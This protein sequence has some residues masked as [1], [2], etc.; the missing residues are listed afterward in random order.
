MTEGGD[1]LVEFDVHDAVII[2]RVH[3]PGLG[4]RG[5]DETQRLGN[6]HLIDHDLIGVQRCFR[7]PVTGLDDRRLGRALGGGDAGRAGKETPDRNRVGG[8]V[9]A[10]VDDLEHII[11]AQDRRG[12][13][14]PAGAPA[15]RQRH[16]APAERH[17]IT[18]DRHRLEQ[19]A[20]NHAFGLLVQISEVVGLIPC[21]PLCGV[22]R[23]MS[24]WSLPG[25]GADLR[26][27]RISSSSDWK[28]T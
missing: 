3:G 9:S 5:L 20:T 21:R 23:C 18:G 24:H 28:S 16:F 14:H 8:V 26:S 10:L 12:Q 4:F 27:L 13:L 22:D 6:R 25:F 1:V 19:G 11:G 2:Q 15:I 17:L 7:D